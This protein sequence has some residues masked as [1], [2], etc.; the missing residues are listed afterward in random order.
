MPRFRLPTRAN[1][2]AQEP[3]LEMHATIVRTSGTS[4]NHNLHAPQEH[5]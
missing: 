1:M 2:L 3:D 5:L 4:M